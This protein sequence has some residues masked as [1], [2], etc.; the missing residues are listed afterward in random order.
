MDAIMETPCS[1]PRRTPANQ[2]GSAMNENL[3]RSD[4]SLPVSQ[5]LEIDR[6]CRQFEAAWKAGHQPKAEDFLGDAQEPQRSQLRKEL[7]A[8]AVEFQRSRQA[9]ATPAKKTPAEK[10]SPAVP[11]L[12]EFTRRL[13]ESG[14]MTEQEVRQFVDSVPPQ[15]AAYGGRT[16]G[17]LMFQK[18]L[19][20]RFQAQAIYQ[21]KTHGLVLGNYVMLDKLGQGGMGE[22]Y[23]A[24]HKRMDRTVALKVLPAVATRSPEAV[25]RFQ[26]EVKA[27]ARLSHPNI[28]TAYDADEA[29]GRHF[30]VME[31]VEGQDLASTISKR[32]AL[33]VAMAVDYILQAARGLDYA[34]RQGITHR[35]IKPANLLL[36]LPSPSG[37]GAGGEGVLLPSP[38][39]RGE[40]VKILDMG[41]ARIEDAVG[42]ADQGLTQSGQIM[43]TLDYMAP[44]QALDTRHAD[45]RADIYSLGCTLCFLLTG[46]P[47]YGG[48]TITQKILAHR[49]K[50]IPSLRAVRPDV[51]EA[52]D[53]V[54]QKMLAKRPESRQQT[55][56]EVIAA[57]EAC[58]I[59][60]ES[61]LCPIPV[62]PV[63]APETLGIKGAAVGTS[64]Q[65][66][67]AGPPRPQATGARG[68]I[69][70]PLPPGDGQGPRISPRPY[71]GEGQGPRISPRPYSG[72]GQGPRISPR[73]YSGEG[74]GVRAF[75]ARF[76]RPQKIALAVA[77]GTTFLL[78]LL[79]TVFSM[80]TKDG[81]LVVELSEPDVTVQVLSEEGK[82]QIE[83]PGQQGTVTIGVDPGKHRLRLEKDGTVVFAQEVAVV[84][85]C[86]E[87]IHA[88]WEPLNKRHLPPGDGQTKLPSP[89][90][91]R[92]AGGEGTSLPS[93]SGRGATIGTASNAG[94]PIV[95][96]PL[97]PLTPSVAAKEPAQARPEPKVV[98]ENPPAVAP[99]DT[100]R[101]EAT[102][103]L[104]NG[105]N[106]EMVL[107][108]AGEF[109]MGSPD[110][111][112]GA[113]SDEKPQHRVLITKPFY[114]GKYLVTQEQWEAV[115][116]NN[117]SSFKA[118]KNPVEN[119]S[120]D[121][122]Q[123]FVS[124]L[125]DK[126]A[127]TGGRFALPTE[128]QWEYACRARTT[129]PWYCG[130]SDLVLG[131]YAWYSNNSGNKTHP[132]G[133]KKPN[134]W[135]LYDMHGNV[136]E[137]CQDWYG[138][139]YYAA[140]PPDDPKGPDSGAYR[141]LRGGSWG[142][143]PYV[144]RSAFRHWLAPGVRYLNLGFR[145]ARTP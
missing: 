1:P 79:G 136:W 51:P 57:L 142:I 86:T 6:I 85:G 32:G 108:P 119:V 68:A 9:A 69:V 34:H 131:D 10:T 48:E 64:S 17:P 62:Q 84:S 2:V 135:G 13:T 56:V 98:V 115:I 138:A 41:L 52:L 16:V 45:A 106:L 93:P 35:D 59:S 30:L 95:P 73:P 39:G 139:N 53:A 111:D 54:F 137:W 15:A 99:L 77:L 128:A 120:W 71:S 46:R 90:P 141:V 70:S 81:T 26:R 117:P 122:C 65:N 126:F 47:P 140:S 36:T 11:S 58:P 104:G 94:P 127:K 74:Q 19:L 14:L 31:Y 134:A 124:T 113:Q 116:P 43:G 49:E 67:Y 29:Q 133:K 75:L 33:P 143:R 91:G 38:S 27:A 60:H 76:T 132:V 83:R 21:G 112:V 144:T 72:E 80:R 123:A 92:G 145:V 125:N 22:V 63:E 100:K 61:T 4:V 55:M 103:A 24:R 82:L 18:G 107:I 87:T 37:R 28:V 110:A 88:T 121:D 78:V 130:H 12:E 7:A 3:D 20:T 8:V 101:K 96:V 42:A 5:L 102:Y 40:V 105:V 109:M 97:S 118:P 23:K 66:L 89:V 25:K 114:L 44:E 50:P 129:S